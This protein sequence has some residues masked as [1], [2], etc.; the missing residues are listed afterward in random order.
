VIVAGPRYGVAVTTSQADFGVIGG[1][2]FYSLLEH[3]EAVAVTTPYGQPSA[4]VTVGTLAGHRVA[5]LPRHGVDHRFPPHRVPYRANL[6]ALRSLGVRQVVTGSAVGSL[7]PALGPGALVLPDQILDRTWGRPHTYSDGETG[8]A[9]L[10]FSDPFCPAG[11][12]AARRAAAATGLELTES[13]TLAVINGPRFST[14]AES[15]DYRRSGAS[16]IGMTAM[17][18]AALARELAVCFTSLCLVTDHDAGVEV[19]HG[20][21]HA[22]V[23]QT[24]AQNLPKLRE[25]LV[26]TLAE[27]PAERSECG[28]A[29]VFGDTKPPYQLP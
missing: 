9:H 14:R 24:F 6:W 18:E 11:R 29:D 17:P 2:G 12:A 3:S 13:G 25:L 19:G 16:I 20:V 5:F 22:E 8:V 15:L 1:S 28:C 27:L 23:L 10:S 26:A 7:E 21:T 4:E